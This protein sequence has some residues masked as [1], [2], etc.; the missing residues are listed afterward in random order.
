MLC[1]LWR[2]SSV[3][4]RQIIRRLQTFSHLFKEMVSFLTDHYFSKDIDS[5]TPNQ[6]NDFH[7]RIGSHLQQIGKFAL[8]GLLRNELAFPEKVFYRCIEAVDTGCK[9][10]VISR[11]KRVAPKQQRAKG[12]RDRLFE[13][14]S[15]Q[16]IPKLLTTVLFPHKL[17]QEYLA[18][19]YL[20]S[21][22]DSSR[23]E[24]DKIMDKTVLPRASEFRYVL[25]FTVLKGRNQ[26]TNIMKRL[27][28]SQ[29]IDD[30][31]FVVDVAFESQDE[32]TAGIINR[33]LQSYDKQHLTIMTATP[34]KSTHTIFGHLFVQKQLV[35]HSN[36]THGSIVS[37]TDRNLRMRDLVF[38][39]NFNTSFELTMLTLC[40]ICQIIICT[41]INVFPTQRQEIRQC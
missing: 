19:M 36:F 11:E 13:T 38:F 37:I 3:N 21:L 18:G 16:P 26:S 5:Y 12:V 10:G 1:I 40:I 29:H 23:T 33:H 7:E 27:L 6:L 34:S 31:N 35:S 24:F 22:Y 9:V 41:N 28:T 20:T 8:D 30:T 15:I 39:W 2:G 32:E 4:K 17:F 14:M 25:Y